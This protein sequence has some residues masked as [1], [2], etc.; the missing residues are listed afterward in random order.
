MYKHFHTKIVKQNYTTKRFL[1]L[2]FYAGKQDWSYF[3][4][5]LAKLYKYLSKI[6]LLIQKTVPSIVPNSS[7]K[8]K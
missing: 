8:K 5:K 2:K 1:D 6:I 7:A 4:S 3:Y